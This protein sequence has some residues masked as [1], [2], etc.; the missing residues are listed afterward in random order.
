MR[1]LKPL[2]LS[3]TFLTLTACYRSP[4]DGPIP[5]GGQVLEQSFSSPDG[6][7]KIGLPPTQPLPQAQ[8]NFQTTQFSWLILNHGRYEVS[9]TDYGEDLEHTRDAAEIFDKLRDIFLSKGPGNLEVDKD[10][11]LSGHPGREVKIKDDQG[12]NIRRFYLVGHRMYSV[13]AFIPI[14]LECA[15]ESAVKV[16]DSFELINEKSVANL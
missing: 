9:Y 15:L 7:F 12:I 14:K 6:G 2:I 1:L 11:M 16:L 8:N 5:E 4:C 13:D 10:L 3:V